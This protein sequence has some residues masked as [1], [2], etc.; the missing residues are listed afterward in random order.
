V[1]SHI[2]FA[3]R[4]ADIRSGRTPTASADALIA[5]DLIVAASMEAL[6]LLD[7]ARTLVAANLDLTPTSEFIF[8]RDTKFDSNA[9]RRRVEEAGAVFDGV[10]A[11]ALAEQNFHDQMFANVILLGFSWAK[12]LVPVSLAALH[13]AIALNGVN[14]EE[15]IAAFDLGRV[16][17]LAPE[18]LGDRAGLR[19][20]RVRP[21][22]DDLIASRAAHLAAYQ[23]EAYAARYRVAIAHVRAREQAAGLGEEF[24]RAAAIHLAKLMAYKDEYEVARLYTDGAWE[25]DLRDSFGGDFKVRFLL[26]PPM[27]S[28]PD[29]ITGRPPKI[30]FGAWMTW[31]FKLLARMK[32]LR[33]TRWDLFARSA[34][35]RMEQRLRDEFERKLKRLADELTPATH[36]LAVAIA[37]IPDRIRGFGPVKAK[38]VE[39]AQAAEAE[40]W[41]AYET[42]KA[43]PRKETAPAL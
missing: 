10:N 28:R 33:G 7:A 31:G 26:A 9:L 5:G 13:Q 17:A 34:E 21:A 8:D 6:P 11:E 4:A 3:T 24:T 43:A 23:N 1:L 22:L 15:N 30:A 32:G 37:D 29:P 25:R 14:I 16:A 39:Q 19:P 42:L 41:R 12:G 2:R 27:L 18:R 20:P 35:R 40:L 38:A 36:G